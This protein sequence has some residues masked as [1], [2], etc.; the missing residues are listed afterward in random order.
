LATFLLNIIMKLVVLAILFLCNTETISSSVDSALMSNYDVKF[1]KLDLEASD[2]TNYL[3]GSATILFRIIDSPLNEFIFE[4]ANDYTVDSVLL[5]S[6]KA[7]FIHQDDKITVTSGTDHEKNS[8]A[9]IQIFYFGSAGAGDSNPGIYNKS[10]NQL[11]KNV[12][13]TLSEPYYS[14]KWFPCKQVIT[15]KA[16]S[17]YVFVTTDS[18]LKAGSNG[19][20]TSTVSLPGD[21]VRY[22]WKS[23]YP[24]AYYL[25]FI[26]VGDYNDYSFYVN[27][28]GFEDSI[29]IQNYIYNTAD[30]LTDNKVNIDKTKDL[31]VLFSEKFG[32]YPFREEKYGHTIVPMGGG[33]E[34]QT[35][36]TLGFFSFELIAHELAHQ[37]FGD[38]VTCATW[39]D[40]WINEGFASYSEY[41]ANQYLIS[42]DK[43]S[44]WMSDAHDYVK[45]EP[46]GTIY[47]PATDISDH[48]RIF[49]NRLSYKKGASVIHMI[50]HE[51]QDDSLFFHV[52]KE[53]QSSFKDSVATGLDFK[54]ILEEETSK[55]FTDFFNQWYFGEGYP[56]LD[57]SWDYNDDTLTINSFQTSSSA[58]NP[59]FNT[60][61]EYRIKFNQG[62][63]SIL[64]RQRSNYD[65]YK[66]FLN[67][68]VTDLKVDPDKWLLMD[69][70]VQNYHEKERKYIIA[71]NPARDKLEIQ[72]SKPVEEY[73]IYITDTSGRII[74]NFK[75]NTQYYRLDVDSLSKGLYFILIRENDK[76]FSSKFIKI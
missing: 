24:I 4:L 59:V 58:A 12:T 62:D 25:I 36:T 68:K 42:R 69:I 44:L 34:H 11:G 46:G 40:I 67:K 31:V 5:D 19:I 71:P 54:N 9:S 10:S 57:V 76:L 29:L 64:I 50:R 49:D 2:T 60:L 15:D 21:K 13:Y 56:I 28:S 47:I 16:D 8:L 74:E 17:V 38:N 14:E 70:N 48:R 37:W 43:A 7:D 51:I 53:F 39:Q 27:I 61:V 20:L 33:M 55:D 75:S 23:H 26:A 22:E 65:Q 32:L 72:F 73:R 18:G 3:S 1:Y 41:I 63:T 30:F 6:V 52:L 35:M 45:T 66:I